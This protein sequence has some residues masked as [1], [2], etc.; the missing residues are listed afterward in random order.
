MVAAGKEAFR[1]YNRLVAPISGVFAAAVT[2]VTPEGDPDLAALPAFLD[3]LAQRGCH[4]ALLLGTT[5]EGPSFSSTERVAIWRA[6]AKWRRQ[7]PGFQLFAG[8]GTPSLSESIE[9][10]GAA[11]NL[12]F[13]AVL[14][15][16]P[17]F[18]RNAGEDGLFD[19]YA[20]LIEES[21]PEGKWLLGY[22][23]PAVSGVPLPPA[24]LQRLAGAYPTRFGGLK[25]SS[26]SLDSAR[27]FVEALPSKSVLVGNDILLGPGLAFGAAGCITALAN[28]R[29]P[30][31]RAVYDAHQRGADTSA[32]QA[33][34]DSYR[35]AMDAMP[36]APAY[37]KAMLHAQHDF[38]RW[39]V[40]PPLRD[41][42]AEQTNA[43][44]NSLPS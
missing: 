7:T 41:F 6:A 39:L 10:N 3:F 37:L 22:H 17:Y 40:R 28:L 16:P 38:P 20:Q 11:F 23:I 32:L 44:L 8:T 14:V 27:A 36:P 1:P 4:G 29:S 26:G 31:A 35:T 43:A 13:E 2:P 33:T 9:L 30:E 19:W 15:L 24:L 42:T 25:D 18:F 12:G 21:V 5:G 34:L